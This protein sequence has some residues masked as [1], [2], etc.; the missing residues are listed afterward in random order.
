MYA[1]EVSNNRGQ[2]GGKIAGA[3]VLVLAAFALFTSLYLLFCEKPKT[4]EIDAV[5]TE[6]DSYRHSGETKHNVYVDYTYDDEEYSDVECN[7]Y[8]STMEEGDT[9]TINVD[10]KTGRITSGKIAYYIFGGIL[11]FIA[12][13]GAIVGFVVIKLSK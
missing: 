6:I 9:I 3:I 11:A 12:L 5:I 8:V 2:A 7:F 13:G 10:P 4:E 1:Q